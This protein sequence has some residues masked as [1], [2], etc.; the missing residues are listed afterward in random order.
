M[1]ETRSENIE[2]WRLI[3]EIYVSKAIK[4]SCTSIP[5]LGDK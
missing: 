4:G 5:P 3:D 2:S 1:Q